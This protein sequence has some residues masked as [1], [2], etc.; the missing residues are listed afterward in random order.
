[1]APLDSELRTAVMIEFL[2]DVTIIGGAR[3]SAMDM[4]RKSHDLV[5]AVGIAET[6]SGH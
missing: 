5:L 1:M 3:S 2:T 4:R 6:A